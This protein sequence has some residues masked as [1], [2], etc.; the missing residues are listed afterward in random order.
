MAGTMRIP[1]AKVLLQKKRN[2]KFVRKTK[3]LK[4]NKVKLKVNKLVKYN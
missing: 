1:E 4:L 2:K 3:S